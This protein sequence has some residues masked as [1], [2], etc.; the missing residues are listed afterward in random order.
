[1]MNLQEAVYKLAAIAKANG[2]GMTTKWEIQ[3][4]LTDLSIS[5]YNKGYEEGKKR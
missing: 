3:D 1:M 4:I 2:I 5:E